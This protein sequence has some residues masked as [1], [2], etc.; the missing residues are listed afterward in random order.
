ME[1]SSSSK[2]ARNQLLLQ[3]LAEY[4]TTKK[5]LCKL[6]LV[7][8]LFN[9][10]FT[11]WLYRD[12]IF[13]YGKTGKRPQF[14]SQNDPRLIHTRR[15]IVSDRF[16]QLFRISF[17]ELGSLIRQMPLLQ[18][19]EWH[20]SSER[21]F[22]QWSPETMGLLQRTCHRLKGV[23]IHHRGALWYE[24]LM[25]A[26]SRSVPA[27]L[28]YCTPFQFRNLQYL[29]LDSMDHQIDGWMRAIVRILSVSPQ[30]RGL[31][32]SIAASALVWCLDNGK[33]EQCT[34]FLDKLCDSYAEAGG[35]PLKLKTLLCGQ[36]VIPRSHESLVKLSD[37]EYLQ[38]L[39]IENKDVE[40]KVYGDI[41]FPVYG[42]TRSSFPAN[43]SFSDITFKS[44][45]P[46]NCPRLRRLTVWHYTDDFHELMCAWAAN[47]ALS[48]NLSVSWHEL[49][50][51]ESLELLPLKLLWPVSTQG[52]GRSIKLR[53]LD[54]VF[55]GQFTI[56]DWVVDTE[57]GQTYG[58]AVNSI[59]EVLND[60]VLSNRDSLEGLTVY[61]SSPCPRRYVANCDRCFYCTSPY[62][63]LSSQI[64]SALLLLKNA[65]PGLLHLRE[66]SVFVHLPVDEGEAL[67][68]AVA[69]MLAYAGPR[70][71][72]VNINHQCWRISRLE[73]GNIEL[74][75]LEWE[76]RER[77]EILSHGASIS[78]ACGSEAM[79]ELNND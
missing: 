30:L 44:F 74:E 32:L 20:S 9:L 63:S 7:S 55:W 18:T 23:H 21:R 67:D 17:P 79:M 26:N 47:E 36:A 31:A 19:L 29:T 43:Q 5:D 48:R 75:K 24:E 78:F 40:S 46:G 13:K 15:I 22:S 72:Y 76:E 4:I 68:L 1:E 38:E 54:L 37:L 14:R 61:F 60:L 27:K 12:L 65:L 25:Y 28:E 35:Q 77:V 50:F 66:L 59:G 71:R 33:Q 10:E 16:D 8:K 45:I 73:D 2:F 57:T 11:K 62:F 6:C 39:H 64:W 34:R 52:P 3:I 51:S 58:C 56:L 70:L 69:A 42:H 53:A 49:P 41:V